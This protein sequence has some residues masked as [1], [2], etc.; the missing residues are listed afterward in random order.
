ML[1]I[2][3]PAGLLVTFRLT[4]IIKE[5]ATITETTTLEPVKWEF[6]KSF[7]STLYPLWFSNPE[8]AYITNSYRH[9]SSSITFTVHPWAY[10]VYFTIDGSSVVRMGLNITASVLE[11]FVESVRIVFKEAYNESRIEYDAPSYYFKCGNLTIK[12]WADY[13]YWW[14]KLEDEKA[15]IETCGIDHPKEVFFNTDVVDWV[16][17]APENVSQQLNVTAEVTYFNGT[18]YV[19]VVLPTLLSLVAD[20]GG[21]FESAREITEGNYTANINAYWDTSDCYKIWLTRGQKLDVQTVLRG[22]GVNLTLYSPDEKARASIALER[23]YDVEPKPLGEITYTI[24]D[25]GYWY[26]RISAIFDY[27]TYNLKVKVETS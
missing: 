11:G 17:K 13:N 9:G 25:E 8:E 21:T 10:A 19:K 27:G 12:D 20:V 2:V 4:G 22:A 7:G 6:E 15:F 1:S 18:S 26:V 3:V 24:D 16:L 5:P 23:N 14:W